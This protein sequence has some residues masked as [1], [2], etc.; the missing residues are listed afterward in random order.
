MPFLPTIN[1]RN[2]QLILSGDGKWKS[3]S[4]VFQ[5]YF[6]IATNFTKRET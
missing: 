2:D 3:L 5:N 6:K 1:L 4:S